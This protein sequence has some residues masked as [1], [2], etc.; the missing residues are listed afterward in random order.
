MTTFKV[1]DNR[2]KISKKIDFL[3]EEL[4]G[5]VE[6]VLT[7]AA[8]Y[9]TSVSPV[10]TGTYVTS[11]RMT[12]GQPAGLGSTTSKGKPRRQPRGPKVAEGFRILSNN[13][14]GISSAN[15]G[16]IYITNISKHSKSVEAK[17]VVYGSLKREMPNITRRAA[18]KLR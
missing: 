5:F 10:D 15:I 17:R 14:T 18:R 13:I 7:G 16:N 4:D 6:R 12:V 2:T 11:H 8:Q 9:V 1:V 3:S